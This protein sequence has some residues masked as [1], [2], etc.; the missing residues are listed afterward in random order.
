MANENVSVPYIVLV[1]TNMYSGN[2]ERE[3]TAYCTGTIG[4]CEVGDRQARLFQE[5]V[6]E[7]LQAEFE[8]AL[9]HPADERGCRRPCSIWRSEGKSSYEEVAMFFDCKPTQSMLDLIKQRAVEFSK[10][11]G[12][13]G[14][15]IIHS[16]KLIKRKRTTVDTVLATL[17]P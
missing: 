3:M 4:E 11:G 16:V 10:E 8:D 12:Y 7:E 6:A 1:D 5:E 14:K 15:M 13:N 2:F 9:A 17:I